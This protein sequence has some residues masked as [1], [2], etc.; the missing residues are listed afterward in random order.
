[1]TSQ[2][3]FA[4]MAFL[5]F[6]FAFAGDSAPLQTAQSPK[7]D[8]DPFK[9]DEAKILGFL[10]NPQAV[11][12]L[13]ISDTSFHP[14]LLDRSFKDLFISNIDKEVF[15]RLYDEKIRPEQ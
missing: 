6:F 15:R 2:K 9:M 7:K 12:I 13:D 4:I 8:S 14:I 5:V 10:E 3:P 1:M 11:Y